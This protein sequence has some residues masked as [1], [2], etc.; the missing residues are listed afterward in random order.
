MQSTKKFVCNVEN[1]HFASKKALDEHKRAVHPGS[2]PATTSQR[3]ARGRGRGRAR[4]RGFAWRGGMGGGRAFN[5]TAM[6]P[7][8]S[9]GSVEVGEDRW[10]SFDVN[11]LSAGKTWPFL[12]DAHMS[13]RLRTL[14][15]AYQ[16]IQFLSVIVNVTAQA[17]A[18]TPG[19]FVAGFVMDPDDPKISIEALQ[20]TQGAVVKRWPESTNIKMP[21]TSTLFYTQRGVEV[22]TRSPGR[23]WLF[24][25]GAPNTSVHVVVSV[26][27]RVKFSKAAYDDGETDYSFFMEGKQLNASPGQ[28]C[29]AL[30]DVG[31]NSTTKLD[32]SS[33]YPA[34]ARTSEQEYIFFSVPTFNIEYSEGSGDTGTLECHFVVFKPSDKRTYYS[35]DGVSIA[36]TV[37]QTNVKTQVCVPCGTYFRHHECSKNSQVRSREPPPLPSKELID[38]SKLLKRITDCLVLLEQTS[39]RNCNPSMSSSQSFEVIRPIRKASSLSD[40]SQSLSRM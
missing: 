29:L 24:C 33:I 19:G 1:R 32:T 9:G 21:N 3:G 39:R 5:P 6:T 35:M 34:S 26:R 22:R 12:I 23:F 27:W 36:D 17:S 13:P 4:G 30:S 20:A 28:Y 25:D 8:P 40:L 16:R 14:A 37:W 11:S 15:A 18:I 2:T 7:T 10:A 31:S 38:S